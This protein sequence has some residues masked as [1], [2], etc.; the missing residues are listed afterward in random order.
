MPGFALVDCNNFYASCERVFDPRLEGRPIVVLSNNDGCV[1]ARSNEAK[2]LGI[3]MGAP[4]HRCRHLLRRHGVHVFSSNYQLYGDMSRRV[5]D[6][7]RTIA[8]D[9]EVYS[10]DEAFLGLDR[11]AFATPVELAVALRARVRQWTG[12]PVSV[13][14]GPTKTLAKLANRHAKKHVEAGV[15]D[16][17]ELA[18]RH[19]WLD[20]FEIDDVWGI[21]KAW[22]G[23]LRALGIHSAGQLSRADPHLVRTHLGVVAERIA[24]ELAGFPCHGLAEV[25]APRKTILASR[26][27]GRPVTC[28]TELGHAVA[29]FAA[30]ACRKLRTQGSR[31]GA[32]HVFLTTNRFRAEEPQYANALT[33]GL[34][35]PSSDTRHIT[36]AA[37]AALTRIY[38]PAFRYHKAGIMLLDIVAAKSEQRHLF[39][40]TDHTLSDRLMATVDR[41][42]ARMGAD[43]VFLAAAGVANGWS[44]R[45]EHRSPRYTTQWSELVRAA[46]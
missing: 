45:A 16:V 43:T 28:R 13:G 19:A 3:A 26:S 8:P 42:N 27:F 2:A 24:R 39:L 46:A 25:P 12:I 11:I 38:K 29:S 6:T 14:I 31:A 30:R 40:P 37:S 21:S 35:V 5:M 33:V 23:R 36:A 18:D 9:I 44:M 22:G 4:F 10:I 20:R 32:V 7:L 41:L 1:I 15:L 34:D 17:A